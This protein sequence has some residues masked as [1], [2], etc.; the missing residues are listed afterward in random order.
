[1]YSPS[2]AVREAVRVSSTQPSGPDPSVSITALRMP[3]SAL[4]MLLVIDQPIGPFAPRPQS[5]EQAILAESPVAVG[6]A[7]R[8]LYTWVV[9]DDPTG[10]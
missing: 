4:V 5:I 7:T 8:R 6:G 3:T 10:P 9:R 2:G 1:M